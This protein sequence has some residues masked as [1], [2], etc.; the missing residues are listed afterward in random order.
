MVETKDNHIWHQ[1][2]IKSGKWEKKEDAAIKYCTKNNMKYV[3]LFPNDIEE[4][5]KNLLKR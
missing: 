5:F 1:E 2:Q 4:F 3:L